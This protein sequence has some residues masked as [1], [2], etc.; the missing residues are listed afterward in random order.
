MRLPIVAGTFYPTEFGDL[1]KTIK[2]SF[3]GKLGPGELPGKRDK[4]ILGVITPHAGY[5]FSG[6]CA[7]WAYKEVAESEF[8]EIFIILG[9]D[10][11]GSREDSVSTENWQTPLGIVKTNASAD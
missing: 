10:H 6:Q 1:D 2:D 7:A 5:I 9:N 3:L 11:Q 4:N 8:P